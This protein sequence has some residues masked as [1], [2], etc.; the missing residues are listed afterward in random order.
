MFKQ[1]M[2]KRRKRELNFFFKFISY[3]LLGLVS[4]QTSKMAET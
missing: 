1:R 2:E 3:F 4:E